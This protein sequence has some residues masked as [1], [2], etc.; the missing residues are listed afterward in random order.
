[1]TTV[2]DKYSLDMDSQ[3]GVSVP[4]EIYL[5]TLLKKSYVGNFSK[6]F[7]ILDTKLDVSKGRDFHAK[8]E[9]EVI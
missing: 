1:M 9:I 5:P 2:T 7:W 4:F 3:E 8:T 6:Y